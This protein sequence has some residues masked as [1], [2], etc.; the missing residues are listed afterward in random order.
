[1]W[2]V[3]ALSVI[4]AGDLIAIAADIDQVRIAGRLLGGFDTDNLDDFR[5]FDRSEQR[6]QDISEAN[7][8]L[9]FLVGAVFA[10]GWFSPAYRNLRPLGVSELRFSP[11]W[12]VGAWVVPVLNLWRPKQIA[13]DIWR[14]SDPTSPLALGP[15]WHARSVPRFL[16]LWWGAWI[17]STLMGRV[18]RVFPN[19][20]IE[21]AR[22]ADIWDFATLVVDIIAAGLAILVVRRLT[23]R[24][25]T[26]ARTLAAQSDVATP[27][28]N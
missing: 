24:Q 21:D 7:L 9:L 15:H 18:T 3:G 16:N 26:R 12:A 8:G 13:D 27:D 28:P 19:E 10:W 1:M 2:V 22:R 20:T 5:H 11:G 6:I 14:A 25:M 4:I 23:A 17:V